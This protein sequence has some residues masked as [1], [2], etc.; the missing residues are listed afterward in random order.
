VLA[1]GVVLG[2]QLSAASDKTDKTDQTNQ[3]T[4]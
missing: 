3:T 4:A 2:G 1:D